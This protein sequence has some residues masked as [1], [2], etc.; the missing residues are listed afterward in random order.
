VILIDAATCRIIDVNPAAASMID[1]ARDDIIDTEYT[2]YT[3]KIEAELLC[4]KGSPSSFT[5][6]FLNTAE[7]DRIPVLMTAVHI[8]IEKRACLLISFIDITPLKLVQEE[9]QQLE[10]KLQRARKMES[11]GTLAGGV[12]H[13]LNNILSG[14]VSY[15]DLILL[16]IDEDSPLRKP[17]LNIKKSGMRA[18]AIVQDLLTL[19]RRNVVTKKVIDLNKLINDFLVT[20]ECRKI[21]GDRS[22]ITIQTN[23]GDG[24][25][26]VLGSETHLSKAVMNL[27]SNAVDAMPAGGL[28]TI[29]TLVR[30]LD[31]PHE[32]HETI[33]KGEYAV[34]QIGDT[35]I[36]MPQSDLDKIFEPFYTKKVLG[37]SGTGL[38]MSVVWGTVKDHDGYIDIETREG[39]GTTFTL[40][41]PISR[42]VPLEAPKIRIDDYL[43]N[44]ESI[45]IVDDAAEQRVLAS[46]MM[47]RLGY[48][49]FTA[50]SGEEAVELVSKQDYD[51]L[52]LDMILPPGINGLETYKRI[53]KLSPGQKAVI[54]SGYSHSDDVSE[55]LGLGAGSYVKKPY[56][57]ES[58]G[59]AVR[60]ELDRS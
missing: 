33:P 32:G 56:T 52:I 16:D 26:T 23:L 36:G 7:G 34:L 11:L 3:R 41:F 25:T 19:A 27:I 57:L 17:L 13:D 28:I 35:G 10:S 44:G 54:A 22:N 14:I 20:P 47:E 42:T 45:L 50:S 60:A 46:R 12:A 21:T 29:I 39:T 59:L 6:E 2:R 49:V 48:V 1:A 4:R 9:R 8:M 15:P 37:Q 30:Y 58:I 55:A 38:G 40:Y 18:S 24:M 5:D 31:Q 51:L 53:L 43:G